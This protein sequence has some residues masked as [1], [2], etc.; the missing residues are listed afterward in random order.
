MHEQKY[1]SR[2]I[3]TKCG[4]PDFQFQTLFQKIKVEHTSGSIV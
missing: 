3:R 1:K 2:N 4:G